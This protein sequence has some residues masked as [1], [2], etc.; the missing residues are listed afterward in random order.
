MH[1]P[2]NEPPVGPESVRGISVRL[3][4]REV[5]AIAR[6]SRWTIRRMWKSGE[7]PPPIGSTFRADWIRQWQEGKTDWTLEGERL[8][9]LQD[10]AARGRP[11][12]RV[13]AE[14]GR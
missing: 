6:R 8:K 5:E 14:G 12:R 9:K 4:Y 10:D 3:T 1:K 13:R 11:R 7:F 2:N